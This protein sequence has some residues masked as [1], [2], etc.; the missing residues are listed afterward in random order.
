MGNVTLSYQISGPKLKLL[1]VVLNCFYGNRLMSFL[2]VNATEWEYLI[3]SKSFEK[4]ISGNLNELYS[5]YIVGYECIYFHC[6]KGLR[7]L[8]PRSSPSLNSLHIIK[9]YKPLEYV[10]V[11]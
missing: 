8:F 1:P 7:I 10:S 3:M 11:F 6:G 5:Y 9:S 4:Y 2:P